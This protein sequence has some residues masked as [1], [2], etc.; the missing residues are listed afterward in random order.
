MAKETQ[1]SKA[2]AG[3]SAAAN[4]PSGK[5]DGQSVGWQSAM[6]PVWLDAMMQMNNEIVNFVS[7]R[8]KEDVKTQ[9]ELL[10]CNDLEGLQQAQ[11]A[12]LEKAYVHYTVEAGKLI[13]MGMQMIP[14][15][16]ASTHHTPV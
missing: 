9:S 2:A 15:V 10:H 3:G 13:K 1:K 12:Y 16:P 5:A 4:D 7:E 8:L 11:L 6:G 14:T